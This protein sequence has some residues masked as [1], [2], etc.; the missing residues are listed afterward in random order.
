MNEAV[1]CTR[2]A[3]HKSHSMRK[4]HGY[5]RGLLNSA[6]SEAALVLAVEFKAEAVN[7]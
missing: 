3:V 7:E 5:H 2:A 1:L 6:A 4:V